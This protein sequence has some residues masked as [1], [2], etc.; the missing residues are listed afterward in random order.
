M[1][2]EFFRV[3]NEEELQYVLANG[4]IPVSRRRWGTY[5][6]G[7]HVYLYPSTVPVDYLLS[8]AAEIM[9]TGSTPH[10]LRVRLPPA[11]FQYLSEDRSATFHNDQMTGPVVHRGPIVA[12]E[13][14]RIDHIAALLLQVVTPR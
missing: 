7:Q 2:L 10:L 13:D 14:I 11:S 6:P 9:E 3:V 5:E 1:S 12:S 8:R 4:K